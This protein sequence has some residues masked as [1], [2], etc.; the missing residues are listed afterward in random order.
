MQQYE[1]QPNSQNLT[2]AMASGLRAQAAWFALAGQPGAAD[3]AIR[4][5][6]ALPHLSVSQNP[7]LAALIEAELRGV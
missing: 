6:D 2:D 1:Q 4:L 7:V 5:A 3:R